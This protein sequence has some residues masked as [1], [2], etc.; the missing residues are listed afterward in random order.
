M[1]FS[2]SK[3]LAAFAQSAIAPTEQQAIKGG[4]DGDIIILEEIIQ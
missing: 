2:N 4:E 3:S 1:L